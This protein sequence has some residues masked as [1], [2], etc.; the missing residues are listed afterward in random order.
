MRLWAITEASRLKVVLSWTKPIGAMVRS[1]SELRQSTRRSVRQ[2]ARERVRRKIRKHITIWVSGIIKTSPL[3]PL[4]PEA[5]LIQVTH[6]ATKHA[7]KGFLSRLGG[8]F[9]HF[10]LRVEGRLWIGWVVDFGWFE[11]FLLFVIVGARNKLRSTLLTLVSTSFK[12]NTQFVCGF[13]GT[14]LNSTQI[15]L[16]HFLTQSSF[17]KTCSQIGNLLLKFSALF[18]SMEKLTLER[19]TRI[20]R[21]R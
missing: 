19:A 14:L 18:D 5:K 16:D 7:N 21:R 20:T 6:T 8:F 15:I 1:M 17:L 10:S 2:S 9:S 11:C 13:C 12:I 4:T 3:N